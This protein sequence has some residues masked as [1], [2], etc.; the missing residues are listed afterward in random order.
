LSFSPDGA[1]LHIEVKA[2]TRSRDDDQGFWLSETERAQAERDSRWTIYRVWNVDAAAY[3]ENIGNIVVNDSATWAL[4]PSAWNV[5][6]KK[7]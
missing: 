1:E 2:T 4:R 5:E 7:V 3:C 6:H